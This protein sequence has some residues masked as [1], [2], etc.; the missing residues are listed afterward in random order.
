MLPFFNSALLSTNR[1]IGLAVTFHATRMII[2]TLR[3]SLFV[4]D[5]LQCLADDLLLNSIDICARQDIYTR[6]VR[7]Q[8][9]GQVG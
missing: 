5:I 7:L 1:S 8:G 9:G 6:M 3:Y 4:Q 2:E